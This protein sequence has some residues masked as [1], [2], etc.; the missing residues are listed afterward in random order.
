MEHIENYAAIFT[1]CDTYMYVHENIET[2]Y[3]YNILQHI[4]SMQ[5]W[6]GACTGPVGTVYSIYCYAHFIIDLQVGSADN[7]LPLRVLHDK[8]SIHTMFHSNNP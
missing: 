3:M 5:S 2:L 8:S 7:E 4:V 6:C 1:Y